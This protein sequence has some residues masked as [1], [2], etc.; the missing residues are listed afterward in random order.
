MSSGGVT[1]FC[2][3]KRDPPFHTVNYLV[4]I[5]FENCDVPISKLELVVF[6]I[7]IKMF[8]PSNNELVFKNG[9]I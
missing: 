2:F 4:D 3:S 9:F 8:V 5:S 1:D 7:V 6:F